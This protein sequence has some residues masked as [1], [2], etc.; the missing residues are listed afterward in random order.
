MFLITCPLTGKAELISASA[1]RSVE[2]HPTH[3]ALQVACPCGCTH[4][5]RTGRRWTETVAARRA[6]EL[7]AA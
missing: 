2:N 5:H 4:V 6:T 7:V 1:I 3:I